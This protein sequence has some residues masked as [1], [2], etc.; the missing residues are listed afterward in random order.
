MESIFTL[1]ET[2]VTVLWGAGLSK[3]L[4]LDLSKNP[5]PSVISADTLRPL[6]E[7]L[8]SDGWKQQV[9]SNWVWRDSVPAHVTKSKE[10]ALEREIA[11]LDT[12]I[13]TCQMSTSSGVQPNGLNRRRAIDLVRFNGTGRYAFIELKVDSDNPLYA[14]FEILGYALAYLQAKK[15]K[16]IGKGCHDVFTAK[17][18]ELTVL[19]SE[20]WYKYKTRSGEERSF[21][22][23]WLANDIAKALNAFAQDGPRFSMAFREY[24]DVPAIDAAVTIDRL[25]AGWR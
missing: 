5:R 2:A 12:Q 25:A 21:E 4:A 1:Y 8:N 7:A 11:K 3:T 24:T 17:E 18:I 22:F 23:G 9:G 10:V 6:F 16:W 20:N 14:A 19:G 13:W 15:Q